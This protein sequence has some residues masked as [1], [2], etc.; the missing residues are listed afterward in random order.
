MRVRL[1]ALPAAVAVAP[2][3]AKSHVRLAAARA[4][5]D[6]LGDLSSEPV[7]RK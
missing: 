3:N 2:V 1:S 5:L 4:F 6:S 7:V